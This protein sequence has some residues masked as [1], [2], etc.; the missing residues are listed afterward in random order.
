MTHRPSP[1]LPSWGMAL[2][3]LLFLTPVYARDAALV[4]RS[5][6]S[7]EVQT[8]VTGRGAEASVAVPDGPASMTPL[9][10]A[11]QTD[12]RW[13]CSDSLAVSLEVRTGKGPSSTPHTVELLHT[14]HLQGGETQL[15]LYL[16]EIPEVK[17][18][19]DRD[20]E[21]RLNSVPVKLSLRCQS[22]RVF[23]H[24]QVI[25]LGVRCRPSA[26]SEEAVTGLTG[27]EESRHQGNFDVMLAKFSRLTPDPTPTELSLGKRATLE[28]S[29]V[30]RRAWAPEFQTLRV[31]RLDAGGK[32]VERFPAVPQ[33]GDGDKDDP[34]FD[35]KLTLTP[36]TAGT[37]RFALEAEYL[38]HSRLVSQPADIPV[39]TPEQE[40]AKEAKRLSGPQ[41]MQFFQALQEQMQQLDCGQALVDWIKKQPVIEDAGGSPGGLWYRFTDGLPGIVHCH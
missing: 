31:V 13:D 39:L 25:P 2:C 7:G 21:V 1:S 28:F 29:R 14:H 20:G 17:A 26:P 12:L 38:D 10:I 35:P 6:E 41:R 15:E 33:T 34:A 4:I 24:E 16:W 27:S 18:A 3:A 23:T 8:V 9:W 22:G 30:L 5:P 19:C 32:V 40:A 37:L 36:K 11:A